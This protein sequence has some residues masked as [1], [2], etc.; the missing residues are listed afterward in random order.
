MPLVRKTER[1]LSANGSATTTVE[2]E[3]CSMSAIVEPSDKMPLAVRALLA[4]SGSVWAGLV[5]FLSFALWPAKAS[6]YDNYAY[7]A[8]AFAHGHVWIDWPGAVVDAVFYEGRHYVI[9]GPVPALLMLPAAFFSL[10]IDQRWYAVAVASVGAGAAWHLLGMLG[11]RPL[12]RAL[13][14][15]FFVLGT[16]YYWC[17][18]YGDV[19][20]F[21]H[22]AAVAFTFFALIELVGQGRPWL[23]ASLGILAA[24]CRFPLV[25]ALP[26]YAAYL[27]AAK[28]AAERGRAA[29]LFELPTIAAVALWVGY[30]VSRWG[31]PADIGYTLSYHQDAFRG[32]AGGSPFSLAHLPYQLHAFFVQGP[33]ALGVSPWLDPPLSGLALTWTSPALILALLAREPRRLVAALWACATLVA[34]PSLLYYVAG[35]DQFGM[36]HALDFEPFLLVLMALAGRDRVP[37]WL[38]LFSMAA[39][40]Y[41]VWY[42]RAFLRT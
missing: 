33:T 4:R 39:G 41:G 42:W 11:V 28:P 31:L 38:I 29:W 24:G 30:N 13:L 19:W 17:A 6:R 21:A 15:G 1:P 22:V 32:S 9:E 5:V 25:L 20:F 40:M 14:F 23:V 18:M 27:I 26:V 7:L 12:P 37:P 2:E 3:F 8:R 10:P 35:A 36:R 34:A 16:P